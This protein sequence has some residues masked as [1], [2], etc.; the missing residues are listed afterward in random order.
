MNIKRKI[1]TLTFFTAIIPILIISLITFS[2]FSEKLKKVENQKIDLLNQAI[3]KTLNKEID[4]SSEML[5]YLSYTYT[6]KDNHLKG[7]KI[8]TTDENRQIHMLHHMENLAKLEKTLKFIAFGTADKKMIFDNSAGNQNLSA[9]YDPTTRPWYIGA[10][11]SKGVY[12]SDVFT[13]IGTGNPIVTLSKKVVSNGKVVGVL[14]AMVDLSHLSEEISKYK[15]GTSG[16]FFIVDENNKILIDGGNN[17]KNFSYISKMDL[18]AKDHF[19]VVK[20]TL[21]GQRF[22][23]IKKIK[24]LNLFLI[25]SAYEKDLNSTILKLRTYTV[26]VVVLTIIFILAILS[27]LN[28]SFNNSLNRLTYIIESISRGNYSKNIDKLTKIID[29]KNEFNFMKNAIEKMSYEII[30]REHDLIYISETDQLTNCYSRRAI[31]NFIEKEIEQSKFFDLNFS[32]IM[33]DFDKFKKVND[34]FGHLFGDLVL[35][36]V[37]KVML[38]NIKTTDSLGRYGGEEFLILLP[39][40]KL[41]EGI[42]VAERLRKITEKL[43]WEYDTVI[44]ISMGVAENLKNDDLDSILERVDNLLYKAKNNGRNKVEY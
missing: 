43:S 34:S 27:I 30:K 1:F 28:I 21:L 6:N 7:G 25:G 31:I 15:I 35:K 18:F 38:E 40:T 20:T 37:S 4:T 8:D 44:T 17:K 10:L 26:E 24:R 5:K 2:I 3:E 14:A 33:F 36:D 9:D 29:D 23:H 39:N 11:N 42:K 41:S 13:H 32:L 22:Y 12:L 16:T 19:E